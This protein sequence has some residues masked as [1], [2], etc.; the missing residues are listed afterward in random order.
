MNYGVRVNSYETGTI[1]VG[2][3]ITGVF[4]K[5]HTVMQ[6]NDGCSIVLGE[7]VIIGK[8]CKFTI[9][10]GAC[11]TIENNVCFTGKSMIV[12]SK[13]VDIRENTLLSW[14]VQIMDTDLHNLYEKGERVNENK[15]VVVGRNVWINS[16]CTILKG[17]SIAD[18]CVIGAIIL[19][20][21]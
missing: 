12:C 13:S 9:N 16:N 8:G 15:S 4:E 1:K 10:S 2:K 21:F 11:L 20:K 17:T 7:N 3:R 18:N 6:Y 14:N 5:E 19:P